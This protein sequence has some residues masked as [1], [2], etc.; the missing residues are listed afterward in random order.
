MPLRGRKGQVYEGGIR[1]PALVNWPDRLKPGKIVAPLHVIDWMPTLCGLVGYESPST[2]KWDGRDIWPILS[3]EERRPSNRI[4][5]WKAPRGRASALRSGDWKLVVHE[6]AERGQD[7]RIELFDLSADP[8]EKRDLA[9]VKEANV[10]ELQAKL[11]RQ[12]A[13]DDDAVV[14][15]ANP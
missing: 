2:L 11:R 4:L 15:P 6:A 12:A 13:R 14:E 5:Y 10:Q 9:G 7:Q 8:Y 1:T 3:G